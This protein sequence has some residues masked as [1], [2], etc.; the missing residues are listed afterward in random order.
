[1]RC[2]L[3]TVR[4]VLTHRVSVVARCELAPPPPPFMLPARA[5]RPSRSTQAVIRGTASCGGSRRTVLRMSVWSEWAKHV[6]NSRVSDECRAWIRVRVREFAGTTETSCV[7]VS[8]LPLRIAF[9]FWV[10]ASSSLS[11]DGA[12][13]ASPESAVSR[14]PRL[15]SAR[16]TSSS[17]SMALCAMSSI[18]SSCPSSAPER[19]A[20]DPDSV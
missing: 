6:S 14:C 18:S 5:P 4:T 19:T 10:A 13:R 2:P 7:L 16:S 12:A 20:T 3:C 17:P 9:D 1:M 8:A 15:S 11:D